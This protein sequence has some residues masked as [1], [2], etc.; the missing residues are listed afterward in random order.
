MLLWLLPSLILT[1]NRDVGLWYVRSSPRWGV[2][3]SLGGCGRG[4]V[5]LL[6]T[7]KI[8]NEYKKPT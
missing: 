1:L 5:V 6:H 8:R 4:P 2:V 7:Q 3:K